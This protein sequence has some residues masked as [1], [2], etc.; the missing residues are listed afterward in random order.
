MDYYIEISASRKRHAIFIGDQKSRRQRSRFEQ[1]WREWGMGMTRFTST[2]SVWS[3]ARWRR[4]RPASCAHTVCLCARGSAAPADGSRRAGNAHERQSPPPGK[5]TWA[6]RCRTRA[7][8]DPWAPPPCW[9]GARPGRPPR[10]PSCA[11]SRAAWGWC[12]SPG[13]SRTRWTPANA[14]KKI[15]TISNDQNHVG[16]ALICAHT[17]SKNPLKPANTCVCKSREKGRRSWRANF[18]RIKT[19][20]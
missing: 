11:P 18:K 7:P 19:Q 3:S 12:R 6:A 16:W 2:P 10:A 13:L 20:I 4:A 17:A 5:T 14:R 15:T 8:S 1:R 9:A